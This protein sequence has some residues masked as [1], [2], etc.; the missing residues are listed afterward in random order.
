VYFD[1]L[2][3]F[4]PLHAFGTFS[5]VSTQGIGAAFLLPGVR[6]AWVGEGGAAVLD[7]RSRAGS[8]NGT[9]RGVAEL[10]TPNDLTTLSARVAL[11]RRS[12]DGRSA[13]MIAGGRS[14]MDLM[15]ANYRL[16]TYE[17]E[18]PAY[19]S[20][21]LGRFDLD[22]NGRRRLEFSGVFLADARTD[23]TTSYG[24][25]LA[26]RRS[27]EWSSQAGRISLDLPFANVHSRH[28]VGLSHFAAGI[29]SLSSRSVDEPFPGWWGNSIELPMRSSVMHAAVAGQFEPVRPD[30][31]SSRW[32]LGYELAA[33][34]VRFDGDVRHSLLRLE[35]T[36]T[37]SRWD[38]P[39]ATLWGL[40]RL[41]PTARLLV[42]PG[43]RVDAGPAV[44]NGG[45]VRAQP[46]LNARLWLDS[47]T[48]MSAA[49]GRSF[50]YTQAIGRPEH[51]LS[52]L[53][54]PTALWI[55]A[56]DSTPALR[57]DIATLGIERWLGGSWL[58]SANA[59]ARRSTGYL[60]SDPSPGRLI[61]RATIV[62][63]T[64]RATGIELGIRKLSGRT[65][66]SLSYSYGMARTR[67]ASFDYPSGQDRR[68]GVDVAILTRLTRTLHVSA[69]YTYADGSPFTRLSLHPG[70]YGPG[71]R[72]TW[73]DSLTA[74]FPNAA[75]K[76]AFS[77]LDLGVDYSF[78]IYGVRAATF[79]QVR[80]SLMRRNPG[81]YFPGVTCTEFECTAAGAD[82]G[83]YFLL[84]RT[85]NVPLPV[86]GLRARF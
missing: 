34:R 13:W 76:P 41:R 9:L 54:Y 67:A 47:Q 27:F 4:G 81:V 31:A 10:A 79:I 65:T 66:G 5:G 8:S 20:D 17:F 30:T 45:L 39:T 28:T 12:R 74:A 57:A 42:E 2:P 78:S 61:D 26:A 56:G 44:A 75:R 35:S 15:R 6:P 64:E 50:Q 51:G 59:Y 84:N 55:G 3:L 72:G 29:D 52:M 63:G 53:V 69:A 23:G 82:G 16:Q 43:L 85:S 11:D 25:A 77:S 24:T 86:I 48:V 22:L 32:M 18:A 37:S 33:R 62:Q 73:E 70:D 19:F 60:L 80:N 71:S 7:V 49:V 83:E 21:L 46:R 40:H 58:L 68:H 36:R 1:G 14:L 38:A